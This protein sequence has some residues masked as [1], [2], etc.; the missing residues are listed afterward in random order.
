M[1]TN[2]RDVAQE[3]V[4]EMRRK[5]RRAK[6]STIRKVWDDLF[7]VLVGEEV[8]KRIPDARD[9]SSFENE[10]RMLLEKTERPHPIII[11]DLFPVTDLPDNVGDLLARLGKLS[12]V[13]YA[14][15]KNGKNMAIDL[16]RLQ[17]YYMID[18]LIPEIEM[19][20]D[21]YLCKLIRTISR[22]YATAQARGRT[23]LT[24]RKKQS[25][26]VNY[27]KAEI[28]EAFYH[29]ET[30][31]KSLKKIGENIA[32]YL[33]SKGKKWPSVKTIIRYLKSN[34]KIRND[35]IAEGVITDKPT[36]VQ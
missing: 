31:G 9:Y 5:I 15:P 13:D 3:A 22:L 19:A 27:N 21:L 20:L 33:K 35:L 34:D 18:L 2:L 25:A 1:A 30:R 24:G 12:S 11:A 4:Q 28:E 8:F 7:F 10:L 14:P 32:D 26:I 16:L 36:L 6:I 29:I 23:I 17:D